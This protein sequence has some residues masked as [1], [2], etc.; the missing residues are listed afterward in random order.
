[1]N[2]EKHLKKLSKFLS[3]VLRYKPE[4]IDLSLDENGW[5]EVNHLLDR[6]KATGPG[7]SRETL[8]LV[9]ATN[10]KKR[11]AYSEDGTRIRANQGHSVAVDLGYAQQTPP[12]TLYH[13]TATKYLDSILQTGLEKRT[14][15]HVH[16][17]AH[18][19]TALAVGQRHGKPVILL[20]D[21]AT[22]VANG[23]TFFL[24]ENGVWLTESVPPQYLKVLDR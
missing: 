5:A 20:V 7:I 23:H 19:D 9:V 15:H 8:D 4:I 12:E 21:T 14:R 11:F 1:M 6:L 22:M 10:N 16:L 18:R 3:L 17:S 13:G 2:E 24:S